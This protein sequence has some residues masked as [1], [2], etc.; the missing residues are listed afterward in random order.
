M[1][2][3]FHPQSLA[4]VPHNQLLKLG[5]EDKNLAICKARVWHP[6]LRLVFEKSSS[7]ELG[8]EIEDRVTDQRTGF[9]VEGEIAPVVREVGQLLILDS[10][11]GI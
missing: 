10:A 5:L 1:L 4:P 7:K 6:V 2:E 9:R 3:F 8:S 11:I